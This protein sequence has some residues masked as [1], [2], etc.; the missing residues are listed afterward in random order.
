MDPP[1]ALSGHL[2]TILGPVCR[3]ADSNC[4]WQDPGSISNFNILGNWVGHH[5]IISTSTW[6]KNHKMQT[7]HTINATTKV[8]DPQ[9]ATTTYWSAE[10]ACQVVLPG[11]AFLRRLIDLTI[12]L[13]LPHHHRRL[14]V[15]S[16]LDLEMWLRFLQSFKGKCFFPRRSVDNHRFL[17]LIHRCGTELS[18]D[19]GL[20]SGPAII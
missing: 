17:A 16:R 14:T 3:V 19:N 9:T 5:H 6:G 2:A 10:I 20:R 15:G 11:R 7:S 4:I 18:M 12:G 8:S 13:R 1:R